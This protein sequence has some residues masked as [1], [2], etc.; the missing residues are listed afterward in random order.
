MKKVLFLLTMISLYSLPALAQDD[1][2]FEGFIG[3]SLRPNPEFKLFAGYLT[4][5]EAKVWG[6]IGV[7]GEY[8]HF[9]DGEFGKRNTIMGGPRFRYRKGERY[10][11]FGHV[12]FGGADTNLLEYTESEN[13]RETTFGMVIGG[14]ADII[15]N[16][17]ISIR[18]IQFDIVMT[19]QL[20]THVYTWNES[21]RISF[22][23]VLKFGH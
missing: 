6:P 10:S 2:K 7:V 19:R 4:A 9:D 12:L 23:I 21:H 22:G 13:S 15:A 18:A 5:F 14:G 20:E 3:F 16:K 1:P 17:W 11:P 8:S